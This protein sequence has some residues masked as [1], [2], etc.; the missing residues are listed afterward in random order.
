MMFQG[1]ATESEIVCISF[2]RHFSSNLFPNASSQGQG[3][4]PLTGKEGR[5][6]PYLRHLAVASWPKVGFRDALLV[7]WDPAS[8]WTW[9]SQCKAASRARKPRP[10]RQA[11]RYLGRCGPVWGGRAAGRVQPE[12]LLGR[13]SGSATG[14]GGAGGAGVNASPAPCSDSVSPETRKRGGEE[15]ANLPR[16]QSRAEAGRGLQWTH[17]VHLRR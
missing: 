8:G 15:A 17:P 5:R 2:P 11:S 1:Q 14:M 3:K 16:T 13:T 7:F 12:V 6:Q 10:R 9:W 4:P